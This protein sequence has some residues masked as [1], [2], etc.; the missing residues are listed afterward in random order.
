MRRR[1][2]LAAASAAAVVPIAGCPTPPW[3][4]DL[5]RIDGAKVTFRRTYDGEIGGYDHGP[6]DIA[7][8]SSALDADPPRLSVA[9]VILGGARECYGAALREASL[10]EGT[11]E[12]RIATV[13][14]SSSDTGG[15]PDVGQTHRYSVEIAFREATVP[16]RVVVRHGDETVLDE[17]TATD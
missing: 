6:R 10:A 9:G 3:S 12:L 1:A 13:N 4:E 16:A 11:L 17:P 2:L 14:T 7:E 5:E 15:C 8:R